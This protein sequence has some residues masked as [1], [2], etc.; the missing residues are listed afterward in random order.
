MRKSEFV[1]SIPDE[2]KS[3]NNWVGH[4]DKLPINV[5][6]GES[7]KSNDS[8]TWTDFNTALVNS[9]KRKLSGVGFMFSNQDNFVGIDLDH[10]RSKE[11]G[12]IEAWALEI[13]EQFIGKAYIE[14]SFS[15]TGVHIICRGKLPLSGRRNGNVEMYSDGRYFT[16]TGKVL[17]DYIGIED[18]TVEIEYL[19]QK[20]ISK[21]IKQQE[22]KTFTHIDLNIDEI[23][24]KASN[25]RQGHKFCDLY[26]GN[27]QGYPSQSEADQ[28][29][30]NLLAFWCGCDVAKMD[31]IFRNSGLYREKWDKRRGCLTY[32]EK[33]INTAIRACG[34]VYKP[35]SMAVME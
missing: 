19:H 7:A 13:I 31:C 17:M 6:T 9:I 3:L 1:K 24:E 28:A 25:S 12:E 35:R 4:K 27:F 34:D 15:G 22:K 8:S 18:C 21:P 2:M 23:I 32:G 10:C 29:F 33:T 11:S 30:C 16:I 5:K 26:N 14:V 20:Y